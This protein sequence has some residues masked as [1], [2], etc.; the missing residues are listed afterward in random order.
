MFDVKPY[1]LKLSSNISFV[2]NEEGDIVKEN[3]RQSLYL[4]LL[5]CYQYL[6]LIV[7][8]KVGCVNQVTYTDFS[9]DIFQQTPSIS[10][11]A[12]ELVTK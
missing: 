11:Q 3:D 2:D 4:M 1:I 9:L 5:K 8:S 7:E 6:H 10:E 12:K